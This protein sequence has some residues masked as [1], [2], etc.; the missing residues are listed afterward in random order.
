MDRHRAESRR[1]RL[2][3]ASKILLLP[4]VLATP[5]WGVGCGGRAPGGAPE[6][7]FRP[8]GTYEV[9]MSAQGQVSQGRLEIRGS[10]DNYRGM[11]AVGATQAEVEAIEVGAGQMNIRARLPAGTLVLRLTGDARLMSG[12]WVLGNRRGT[13]VVARSPTPGPEAMEPETLETSTPG[14]TALA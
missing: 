10:P 4:L 14:P 11:L 3:R 2:D 8:L 9:T 5:G 6:P 13:V 7:A 1:E 12:N